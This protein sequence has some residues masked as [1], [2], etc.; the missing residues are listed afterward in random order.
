VITLIITWVF[1]PRET[2]VVSPGATVRGSEPAAV[3]GF[4]VCMPGWQ[5]GK[6]GGLTFSGHLVVW[7]LDSKSGSRLMAAD[8]RVHKPFLLLRAGKGAIVRQP[9][10][11]GSTLVWRQR[12]SSDPAGTSS[13][14]TMDIGTRK[15][16]QI[17]APAVLDGIDM[18]QGRVV[19]LQ[20]ATAKGTQ[21]D[22][23]YMYD[24]KARKS[25]QIPAA[26]GP[27]TDVTF[28]QGVIAWSADTGSTASRGVWLY[29][30]MGKNAVR[31]TTTRASSADISGS[32]V[33]W[34]DSHGAVRAFNMDSGK[35]TL[36]SEG[37]GMARQC[38]VDGSLAVWWD[39]SAIGDNV[40]MKVGDVYAADLRSDRR[41]PISTHGSAQESPQVSG[42]TVVWPD[43][44]RGVWVL[45]AAQVAL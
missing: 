1:W 3:N 37:N 20:R 12:R 24:I 4:E 34:V 7:S 29:E 10:L 28:D 27:K 39:A 9:V 36:V 21:D 35:R 42:L 43:D 14:W 32:F 17:S 22:R 44:S 11:D 31:V 19:W 2:T 25:V 8:V 26:K 38:R 40:L 16:R 23:V 6:R 13:L 41:F 30:P 5:A 18:S 15:V 45:R 33:V